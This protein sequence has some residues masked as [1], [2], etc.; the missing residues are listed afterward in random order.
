MML[1]DKE[2]AISMISFMKILNLIIKKNNW[3][4]K[5][6]SKMN[7]MNT[8]ITMLL[9]KGK[10]NKIKLVKMFHLELQLLEEQVLF[11]SLVVCYSNVIPEALTPPPTFV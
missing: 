4:R 1:K 6:I 2:R 11:S 9:N 8:I 3:K 10:N 5:K 7:K